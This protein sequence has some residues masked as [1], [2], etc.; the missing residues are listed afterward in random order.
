M[1]LILIYGPPA[2]GKLTIARELAKLTDYKVFHNH[3]TVDMADEVFAFGS[4]PWAEVVGRT[5]LLVAE[6][7]ARARVPGLIYTFVYGHPMDALH[8]EKLKRT[9]E[10][11]GGTIHFVQLTCDR[12]TLLRRVG[13][14]SRTEFRKLKSRAKL[15]KLL[16][17]WDLSIPVPGVESLRIDTG[18]TKAGAAARHI[19]RYYRL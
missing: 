16:T 12:E 8:V 9:V 1:R 11:N 14:R 18:K 7:A 3:L 19:K 15:R 13:N 10:K 6:I 17:R 2:S 5:R 4:R